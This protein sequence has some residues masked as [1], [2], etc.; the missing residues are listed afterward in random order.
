MPYKIKSLPLFIVWLLICGLIAFGISAICNI[1]FSV[2]FGLIAF[3]LIANGVVAELED[4]AAGGFLNPEG[5]TTPRWLPVVITIARSV[6]AALIFVIGVTLFFAL[7]EQSSLASTWVL[8]GTIFLGSLLIALT[9]LCRKRV[10]LVVW[11]AVVVLLIG[12][13]FAVVSAKLL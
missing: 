10:R 7:P 6:G 12:I 4:R 2:L 11:T 13:S 8:R 9:L 3:G 5:T 1:P